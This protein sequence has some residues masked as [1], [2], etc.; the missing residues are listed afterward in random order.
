MQDN[1]P[2]AQ[3]CSAPNTR[4]QCLRLCIF[5]HKHGRTQIY[6]KCGST[7]GNCVPNSPSQPEKQDKDVGNFEERSLARNDY[8]INTTLLGQRD[9]QVANRRKAGW[10]MEGEPNVSRMAAKEKRRS[11]RDWFFRFDSMFNTSPN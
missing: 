6:I 2:H 9:R 4:G 5:L 11:I 3:L 7:T 10:R 8:E 1:E